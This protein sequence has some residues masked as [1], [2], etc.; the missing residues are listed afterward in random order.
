MGKSKH[1]VNDPDWIIGDH[2]RSKFSDKFN[3]RFCYLCG[4]QILF[5]DQLSRD[6]NIP[7]CRGGQD[8]P[9]NIGPS[10]KWCNCEKNV[11]TRN[12]HFRVKYLEYKLCRG[13]LPKI[14]RGVNPVEIDIFEMLGNGHILFGQDSNINFD[15]MPGKVM[16]KFIRQIF[17][18][19]KDVES[20]S[21]YHIFGP[22]C[23]RYMQKAESMNWE[24]SWKSFEL[25][26]LNMI[27]NWRIK[28]FVSR[29]A[30]RKY[31]EIKNLTL[32]SLNNKTN[33]RIAL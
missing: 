3:I 32:Q 25:F 21:L 16:S 30:M 4:L 23:L 28:P 5:R 14:I 33:A 9:H 31:A 19:K 12:E 1:T 24:P 17:S 10:H 26:F 8:K 27:K 7:T 15:N 6:H 11:L 29:N 18:L 22:I 2:I 20:S 13:Q